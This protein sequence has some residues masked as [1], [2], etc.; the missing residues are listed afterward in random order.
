MQNKE[1]KTYTI[2]E[3]A[4]LLGVGRNQCYEAARSGSIPTLKIG[5]RILVPKAALDRMLAGEAA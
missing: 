3:A 2:E 5:K 1:R 4:H